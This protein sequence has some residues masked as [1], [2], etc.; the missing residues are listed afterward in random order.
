MNLKLSP[1]LLNEIYTESRRT[2]PEE[3]CG[4]IIGKISEAGD[5]CAEKFVAVANIQNQVHQKDPVRYPRNAKTAYTIDPKEM[6]RLQKESEKSG[7]KILGIFHS[8]PEHGVYFSAEDKEMAAPWGEP[9]FPEISYVVVSV[10]SGE[11]KNCSEFF[12][13]TTKN[14]FSEIGIL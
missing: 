10:Y 12:W 4:F 2:W 6:E 14:D 11:V 5:R 7:Q 9:L 3:G 1:A 8:H 13:D